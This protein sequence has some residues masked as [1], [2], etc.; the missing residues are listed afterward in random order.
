MGLMNETITPG[1][2]SM[3]FERYCAAD[4]VSKSMLDILAERTP[5]HLRAYMMREDQEPETPAMR[6][7]T[8]LHRAL[9]EPDTYAGG[10]HVKPEKLT[11]TTK[12]GKAWK[13]EHADKPV[14]TLAESQQIDAMVSAVHL[15]PFAK[16]LLKGAQ[17][18][19]KPLCRGQSRHAAQVAS[20]RAY[21]GKHTTRHKNVRDSG[22]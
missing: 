6:F 10:F 19:A 15:H 9:L 5:M 8:I 11:F 7:G 20:G 17:H 18:R 21:Y 16:R 22:A 4:G 2:H 14:I 13:D 3:A 1:I 12:T